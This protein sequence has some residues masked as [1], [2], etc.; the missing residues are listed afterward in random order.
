MI[1]VLQKADTL[2]SFT[3]KHAPVS[4]T[5][6]M[7]LSGI[8]KATLSLILKSMVELSWLERDSDGRFR[9]G[10][11]IPVLADS[12]NV[13]IKLRECCTKYARELNHELNELV[14][15]AVFQEGERQVIAKFNADHLVQVNENTSSTPES[16][17]QTATGLV[18]LAGLDEKSRKVFADR[19]KLD[20]LLSQANAA[21]D[22]TIENGYCEM[23]M[24]SDDSLAVAVGVYDTNKTMI[25][26]IGFSA[27]C[28]RFD[29]VKK[30]A[31]VAMLHKYASEISCGL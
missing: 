14:T 1:K 12:K 30:V 24:G 16:M 11:G 25:A 22:R 7:S 29:E 23:I 8:N 18:L 5:E 21:I 19:H 28:Y 27:P 26:T 4:F 13:N 3:A 17:F 20:D 6:L 15:V 9:I 31:A 10:A 2:L